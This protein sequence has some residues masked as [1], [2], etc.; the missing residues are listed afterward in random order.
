MNKPLNDIYTFLLEKKKIDNKKDFAAKIEY[1]YTHLIEVMKTEASEVPKKIEQ[2]I[3]YKFDINPGYW[4]SYDTDDLYLESEGKPS[5]A[6]AFMVKLAK[7]KKELIGTVPNKKALSKLD[8]EVQ[9]KWEAVERSTE[10][11]FKLIDK[12]QETHKKKK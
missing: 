6:S 3:R 8:K 10:E 4:E 12:Q 7:L 11:L 5:V 9:E 2:A 1:N